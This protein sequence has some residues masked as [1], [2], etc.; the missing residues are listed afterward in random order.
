MKKSK[1]ISKSFI[2][3]L[4]ISMLIWVLI[5]MSKEYVTT[6]EIPI[7]YTNIP[8][9]LLLQK[10]PVKKLD[11]TIKASGFKTSMIKLRQK[12]ITLEL[13]N[14]NKKNSNN[15]YILTRNYFSK[16]KNQLRD[17]VELQQ[18]EQDTLHLSLGVLKSKKLPVATNMKIAYHAGYDL[19]KQITISPDSILVSGPTNQIEKLTEIKLKLL[20][21]SDIKSNF[22]KK[23]PIVKPKNA[24]NLKFDAEK[25]VISGKVEKFTEGNLTLDFTIT[26]VPQGIDITTLVKTVN[27]TFVVSLSDFNKVNKDSFIVECN[28]ALTQ[29]NNLNYVMPRIIKKPSF[30]KNVRVV[31]NKIDFL[32]QK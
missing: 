19:S 11:I 32:I 27:V 12:V 17:G 14:L 9:H 23:V 18:I 5:T 22:S 25:V 28:Y 15:Y 16:I 20:E 3:F 6:L 13:T 2:G 8:Q 30:V 31:P 10:E 4:F 7:T 29:N 1:K 24:T 26:N 21:M